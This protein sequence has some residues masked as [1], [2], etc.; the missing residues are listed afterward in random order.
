MS[1]FC[2]GWLNIGVLL[3]PLWWLSI[4]IFCFAFVLSGYVPCL[5]SSLDV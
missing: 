1:S 4:Q 2:H 3:L 5:A